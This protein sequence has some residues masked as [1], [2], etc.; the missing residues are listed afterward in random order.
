M[1]K[2]LAMAAGELEYARQGHHDVIVLND[3]VDRAYKVFRAAVDGTLQGKGDPL[4]AEEEEER[5]A[6]R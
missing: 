6:R 2:R 3:D 1:A 5:N 4:P